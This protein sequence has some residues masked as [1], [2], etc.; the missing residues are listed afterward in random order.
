[1]RVYARRPDTIGIPGV[2]EYRHDTGETR[3]CP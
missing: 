3:R 1:M 2:L